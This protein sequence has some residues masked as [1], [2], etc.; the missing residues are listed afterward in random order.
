MTITWLDICLGALGLFLVQRIF[1]KKPLGR[2]PP[3]PPKWP[4]LGNILDMPT[5]KEWLTFAKWGQTYG[6]YLP[7]LGCDKISN[8]IVA[9]RGHLIG[10]RVRSTVDHCQFRE[11]RHGYA[12]KKELEVF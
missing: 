5:S 11:D 1:G 12:G 2:L 10:D 3:G 8:P 7:C 4:L 6:E 9:V